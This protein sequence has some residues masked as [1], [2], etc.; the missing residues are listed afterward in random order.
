MVPKGCDINLA[1]RY[2]LA[3]KPYWTYLVEDDGDH[4]M[5]VRTD[6]PDGGTAEQPPG[7]VA[8]RT[9]RGFLGHELGFARSASGARC[10]VTFLIEITACT[11]QGLTV[12]VEAP[13]ALDDQCRIQRSPDG[14]TSEKILVRQ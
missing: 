2:K 1:G 13:I 14:A 10:P 4:L 7:M 11:P 6:L 12:R 5:A 3:T 8:D 9:P